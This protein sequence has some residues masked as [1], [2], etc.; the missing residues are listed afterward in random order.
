MMR[1]TYNHYL[2]KRQAP[3]LRENIGQ[4]LVSIFVLC[5]LPN[6]VLVIDVGKVCAMFVFA[7]NKVVSSIQVFVLSLSLLQNPHCHSS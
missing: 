5:S 2:Y 7:L 1:L 6:I 4:S 3:Q